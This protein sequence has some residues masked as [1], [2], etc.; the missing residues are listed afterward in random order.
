MLAH[1]VG[2]EAAEGVLLVEEGVALARL[3]GEQVGQLLAAHGR[4]LPDLGV[5]RVDPVAVL[6]DLDGR[7]GTRVC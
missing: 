1:V 6:V 5:V 3:L 7:K 2:V 4:H